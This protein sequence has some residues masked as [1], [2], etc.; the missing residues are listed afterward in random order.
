MDEAC[1]IICSWLSILTNILIY[2]FSAAGYL[3]SDHFT[4]DQYCKALFGENLTIFMWPL[5][6][7]F[8]LFIQTL[9]FLEQTLVKM[10]IQCM[11]L[12][13]EPTTL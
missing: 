1:I 10:S 5:F 3:A 12:V 4:W 6:V 9:Q 2:T 7:Y 8:R 11:V 13:F